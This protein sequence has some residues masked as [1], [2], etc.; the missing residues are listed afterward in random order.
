[1]KDDLLTHIL[2]KIDEYRTMGFIK[3]C[4]RE[5]CH[6]E[7]TR[8]DHYLYLSKKIIIMHHEG[9]INYPD[10]HDIDF[11]MVEDKLSRKELKRAVKKLL[12]RDSYKV[13]LLNSSALYFTVKK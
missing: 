3:K 10:T 12:H 11:V 5:H 1:M 13:Q 6:I 9:E 2:S 4:I 7:G 8:P